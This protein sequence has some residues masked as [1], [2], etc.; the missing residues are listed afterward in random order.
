MIA[1][2]LTAA[3]QAWAAPV[4]QMTALATAQR[5]IQG[6][7]YAAG[8]LMAPMTGNIK[9]AHVEMNSKKLD[10]AVY[11]VFNTNNGYVIVSGDDRAEKILGYGD[12]PLDFSTIPCNMKA[13]LDGYKD[14][15][16]YLQANEGLQVKTSS[17]APSLRSV[18]VPPLLTALWDQD[19]PYYNQCVINGTQCV[20]GCPATSAAMVFYYWKYPDFPTPVVPAYRCELSSGWSSSYVNVPA[21]PSV[22]FDWDNMLDS[23]TGGYSTVQGNAVAKLMRYVGQ[24]EHMA[25]G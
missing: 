15:I 25:Y 7:T 17:T 11:Y 5:F 23:Y 3:M 20:T 4:D 8:Q 16:E 13:W 22:T 18:S 21:L 6:Q 1:A 12:R 24:A 14:A 9:L 10:R 19:A 2:V